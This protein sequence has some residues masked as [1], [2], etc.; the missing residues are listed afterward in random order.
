MCGGIAIQPRTDSAS[1]SREI[2]KPKANKRLLSAPSDS[3]PEFQSGKRLVL[4]AINSPLDSEQTSLSGESRQFCAAY[5]R[6]FFRAGFDECRGLLYSAV[7]IFDSH[8]LM[9]A[10]NR[11]ETT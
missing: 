2:A 1:S 10:I 9:I 11:V 4:G 3:P 8:Q 5:P 6:R 7:F